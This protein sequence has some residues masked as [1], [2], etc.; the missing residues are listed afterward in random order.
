[1]PTKFD[2]ISPGVLLREIDQ[3]VLPPALEEDGPIIIG[4]TRKGPGMKPV[5]VKSMD[6]FIAVFGRP[7]PGGT[8]NLGDVWRGGNTVGP[9]YAAYAAQ[10]W[11][12]S[13]NSPVTMV[14]LLGD[15]QPGTTTAGWQPTANAANSS[16]A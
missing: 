1:M 15:Q 9:T 14:R 13:G 16:A 10:A 7:V 2:F 3:S 11:L 5:K 8:T 4:R 12:A 6:D